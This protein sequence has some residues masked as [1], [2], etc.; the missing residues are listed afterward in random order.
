MSLIEVELTD[1][2]DVKEAYRGSQY[3]LEHAVVQRLRRPHQ[4]VEKGHIPD[5]AKNEGGQRQSCEHNFSPSFRITRKA[6]NTLSRIN[7]GLRLTAI[8]TQVEVSIQLLGE[9][10]RALDD[11]AVIHQFLLLVS[12]DESKL[13]KL[14]KK[15]PAK[16][17]EYTKIIHIYQ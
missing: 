8:N 4:Y 2:V 1:G 13:S 6:G 9:V 7:V 17:E 11:S 16:P 12:P 15:K 5:K 10:L 3:S 14:N